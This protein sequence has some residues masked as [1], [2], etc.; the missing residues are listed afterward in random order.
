MKKLLLLFASV[1]LFY[2]AKAQEVVLPIDSTTNKICYTDVVNV[3]GK[4]QDELY[5][6][7]KSWFVTTFNSS[8]NVI[9]LDDKESGIIIGKGQIPVYTT[10]MVTAPMGYI[11]FLV[12]IEIKDGR[13]R[14][15]FTDLWHSNPGSE[16]YTPGDLTLDRPGGGLL[17]M[18]MKN[19]NGL[20]EQA[21]TAIIMMI[22]KLKEQMQNTNDDQW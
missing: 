20:K 2:F 14:Y 8:Q 6:S 19:W 17:S 1:I 5:I 3:E 12:K 13:Y 18:G 10:S 9:D 15:T 16:G 22:T 4:T 7:A 11:S 21:N